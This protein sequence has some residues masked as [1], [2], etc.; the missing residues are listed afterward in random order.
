MGNGGLAA[1]MHAH[2]LAHDEDEVERVIMRVGANRNGEI[3]FQ[4]FCALARRNSEIEMVLRMMRP[5]C[6]VASHFPTGTTLEDFATMSSAQ[7]SNILDLSKL[8]LVQRMVDAARKMNCIGQAQQAS[9]GK[10]CGELK[11]G[12]YDDFLDGVT[13]IVG[14]PDADL[15]KGMRDEHTKR[16]DSHSKFTTPNYG[17]TTTPAIEYALMM[18]GGMSHGRSGDDACVII[19]GTRGCWFAGKQMEDKRVLRP[20]EHYGDFEDD[21]CLRDTRP[22]TTDT[23]IQR[24]VK[25]ASLRRCDVLAIILYT[26]PMYVLYNSILRGFGFCGEVAAHIEFASDKFWTQFKAVSATQ[27]VEPRDSWVQ[28]GGH[29]F[30]NTIHAL[31]SAIK[32]LKVL[33]DHSA[34]SCLYRGLGGL[35]VREFLDSRGFTDMAFMS[36]SKRLHTALEYRYI[37]YVYREMG[38]SRISIEREGL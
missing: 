23:R 36:T 15:E 1:L 14:E 19:T 10:F 12:T 27:R 8:A 28:R 37:S 30:T 11:G 4:E 33:S 16:L 13:G 17:I 25:Q 35:D 21:G 31:A 3:N 34:G 24:Q 22:S 20:I 29:K 38:I 7:F 9:N 18:S 26:G 2:Q 6:V 32:K 5:E